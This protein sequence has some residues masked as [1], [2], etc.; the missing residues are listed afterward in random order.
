MLAPTDML[1]ADEPEPGA[2]MVLGLKVTLVP[3]GTP[4]AVNATELLKPPATEVV[5]VE[6][7]WFPC[8]T[9][10]DDGAVETVKLGCPDA[11]TVIFTTAVS[12]S[13]PPRP[14]TTTG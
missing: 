14:A 12:V 4:E 9:I 6:V 7:P 13:P 1:I 3:D 5:I 2:A 11:V 8:A 10:S